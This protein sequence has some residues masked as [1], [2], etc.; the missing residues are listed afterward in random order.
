MARF[1]RRQTALAAA[2][3]ALLVAEPAGAAGPAQGFDIHVLAPHVVDGVVMGP[4]HHYC[5]LAQEKPLVLECLLYAS[6]EPS[7]RLVGVEY[8]VDK[9]LTRPN[10]RLDVWNQYY[11]D[12]EIEIASGRVAVL[13]RPDA[14]A[15]QLAAAAAR[16]DGIIWK[17]WMP[18][19][20]LPNGRAVPA[21]SVGHRFRS[22]GPGPPAL[23][24]NVSS[25]GAG[26]APDTAWCGSAWPV[27]EAL[28]DPLSPRVPPAELPRAR[29]ERNPLPAS[30]ANIAEGRALYLGRGACA[31]CHGRDGKGFGADVDASRLGGLLPRDLT[32]PA[33]HAARAD[34]ELH[35]VL[36][37]GSPGTAMAAFVPSMLSD[38]EAWR[39]VHYLRVLGRSSLPRPDGPDRR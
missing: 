1:D 25:R 37:N 33:W 8:F 28:R 6:P 17:L 34:G 10:L 9:E 15:K 31:A 39:V 19:Q 32:D 13:D 35:W 29:A 18:G 22:E 26:P 27:A 30:A 12:H 38:E 7:A 11:H 2:L 14:E 4:F 3:L 16:T 24:P 20:L 23:P 36:R 5:K 21:Q